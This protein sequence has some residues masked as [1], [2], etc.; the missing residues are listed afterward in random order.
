MSCTSRFSCS[1]SEVLHLAGNMWD[2]LELIQLLEPQ[3][4]PLAALVLWP[5]SCSQFLSHPRFPCVALLL[6]FSYFPHLLICSQVKGASGWLFSHHTHCRPQ[7]ITSE[8]ERVKQKMFLCYSTWWPLLQPS[9]QTNVSLWLLRNIS[10]K[11]SIFLKSLLW[12]AAG[13]LNTYSWVFPQP[14]EWISVTAFAQCC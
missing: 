13:T 9:G 8:Q 11:A 1:C 7:T 10:C 12:R 5:K 3:Y 6:L 2:V 4:I 14:V